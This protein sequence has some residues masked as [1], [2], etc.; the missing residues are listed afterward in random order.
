M[1]TMAL[2]KFDEQYAALPENLKRK[3]D[4]QIRYLILNLRH[5]SLHSKKYSETENLW[6]ARIDDNYRFYFKIDYETYILVL[7]KKHGD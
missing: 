4:K 3:I 6:Q 5:P 7:I 2:K 1:R